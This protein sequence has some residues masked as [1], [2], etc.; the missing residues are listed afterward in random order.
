MCREGS[1]DR[2]ENI[3]LHAVQSAGKSWK[4]PHEVLES[5]EQPAEMF[6]MNPV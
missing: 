1:F 3:L 5:P 4:T 6:C 2:V